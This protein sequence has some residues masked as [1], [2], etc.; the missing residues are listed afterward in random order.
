MK[1][2]LI[3]YRL[4]IVTIGLLIL[5]IGLGSFLRFYHIGKL[6]FWLDEAFKFINSKGSIIEAIK[7]DSNI[8]CIMP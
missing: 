5:I 6:S 1:N 2:C 4:R 3:H 8:V 7:E